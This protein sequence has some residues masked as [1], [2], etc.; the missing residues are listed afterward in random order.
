MIF[1][2][3]KNKYDLSFKV[4]QCEYFEDVEDFGYFEDFED[5][6]DVEDF[7]DFEDFCNK[8]FF[9]RIKNNESEY[10]YVEEADK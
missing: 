10:R 5:F 6:E 4:W 1:I 9:D 3:I 8:F 2:Y 7:E